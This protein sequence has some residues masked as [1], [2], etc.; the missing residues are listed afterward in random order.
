MAKFPVPESNVEWPEWQYRPFPRWIGRDENGADLIAQNEDEA[1]ALAKD[2]VYPKTLG[3]DKKGNDVVALDPTEERLKQSD[4][5]PGAKPN[6][7]T[8]KEPAPA[9]KEDPKPA[10]KK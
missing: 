9:P 1:K 10:A 4:V 3:V 5:V 8:D 2:V 7:L 6:K